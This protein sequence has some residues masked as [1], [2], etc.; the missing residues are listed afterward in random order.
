VYVLFEISS[1]V[2]TLERWGWVIVGSQK[3]YE[4]RKSGAELI[5][6]ISS[7]YH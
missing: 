4:Y 1:K 6:K 2:A 3:L 7:D 5:M